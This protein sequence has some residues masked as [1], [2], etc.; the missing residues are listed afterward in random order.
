MY[1]DTCDTFFEAVLFLDHYFNG[2]RFDELYDKW[3]KEKNIQVLEQIYKEI[4]QNVHVPDLL[5]NYFRSF[6]EDTDSLCM[7]M[8]SDIY[9][10]SQ[11]EQEKESFCR[12]L[13][14]EAMSCCQQDTIFMDRLDQLLPSDRLKWT[15]LKIYKDYPYHKALLTRE[16]QKVESVL[17]PI[18]AK[19]MEPFSPF[20]QGLAQRAT[21]GLLF[22]YL[23]DRTPLDFL[24]PQDL[25]TYPS[26]MGCGQI[27]L[28]S[29]G[30]SSAQGRLYLGLHFDQKEKQALTQKELL[31][32]L[33]L[34]SD[35]SKYEILKSIKEEE[36]YGQQLATQLHLTTATISHHMNSL[37]GHSLI[38]IKKDANRFYYSLNKTQLKKILHKLETDLLR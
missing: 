9:F 23:K 13:L 28:I 19:Y 8:I 20:L 18:Y 38:Q 16:I 1:H 12:C 25:E 10:P 29:H 6:Q 4:S 24:G 27:R 36:R 37:S 31:D 11:E 34:L 33:K 26:L 17:R 7:C 22:S 14:G 15:A 2:F 35:P 21:D 32:C 5:E 3:G 30:S